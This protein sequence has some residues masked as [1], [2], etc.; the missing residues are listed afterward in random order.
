MDLD[1]TYFNRIFLTTG[2]ILMKFKQV[3][4]GAVFLFLPVLVNA[5][6]TPEDLEIGELE[7]AILE[8]ERSNL[9]LERSNLELAKANEELKN[10]NKDSTVASTSISRDSTPSGSGGQFYASDKAAQFTYERFTPLFNWGNSRITGSFLFS[11]T[12]DITVV[13][14]VFWDLGEQILPGLEF[15]AG[16]KTYGSLIGIE[17][18]D[19]ISFGGAIEAL[20]PL[21]SI[22]VV[23]QYIEG[24]PLTL[25]GGIGIAPDI[26]SF[27]EA[28]RVFDWYARVGLRASESVDVFFGFRFLQFDTQAGD[29]EVDDRFHLGVKWKL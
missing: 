21:T 23:G 28:D 27:G 9:E 25:G 26:L 12:R 18:Q 22:P 17:N 5:G 1:T 3:T 7:R 6:G 16:F 29:T 15:S 20:Y 11:E 2:H 8:L 19:A 24:F 13:G 14:G 4:A 10:A